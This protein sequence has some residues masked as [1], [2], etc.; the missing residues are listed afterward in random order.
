M[1]FYRV[2]WYKQKEKC[3]FYRVIFEKG[4]IVKRKNKIFIF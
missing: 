4:N 2:D 1:D 3:S